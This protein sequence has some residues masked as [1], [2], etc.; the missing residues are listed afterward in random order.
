MYQIK[1]E[2]LEINIVPR[3]TWVVDNSAISVLHIPSK[4]KVTCDDH[5]SQHKNRNDCITILQDLLTPFK[6]GDI[7]LTQEGLAELQTVDEKP[8][9]GV[10]Y[11]TEDSDLLYSTLN[12]IAHTE[13]G[14]KYKTNMW[15]G[16]CIEEYDQRINKLVG[17]RKG[18]LG[19][20]K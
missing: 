1:P 9:E 12:R 13:V 4:I 15:I 2:D 7:V 18:L 5:R 20:V 3:G 19:E 16:K 8:L 14:F 10:Y 17:I 11:T 6:Q